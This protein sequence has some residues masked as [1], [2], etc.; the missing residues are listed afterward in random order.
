MKARRN[1]TLGAVV[2]LMALF[3]ATGWTVVAGIE[4]PPPV[5]L[6]RRLDFSRTSRARGA[7]GNA[8][9]GHH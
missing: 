7:R 3:F 6:G 9:F 4:D 1:V 8:W 5:R 2:G